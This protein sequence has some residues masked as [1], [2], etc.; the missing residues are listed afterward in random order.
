LSIDHRYI[1]LT[2]FRTFILQART[3]TPLDSEL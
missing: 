2:G 1:F 3:G